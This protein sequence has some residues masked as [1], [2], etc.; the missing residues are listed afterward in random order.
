VL[1][2]VAGLAAFALAA[3]VCSAARTH[4]PGLLLGVLL[5]GAVVVVAHHGGILYGLPVG[6][7]SVLAFDWYF[8]PPLRALDQGTVFVLGL[9]LLTAVAV[10]VLASRTSR[11]AAAAE[12]AR[13]RLADEQ[14]ALRRV[15]TLIARQAPPDEVFANVSEEVRL[16][17]GVDITSMVRF[18][19]DGTATLIGVSWPPD[20]TGAER[21]RVMPIG[22][23]L[24]MEGDN[25]P[26]LVHRTGGPVRLD[27]YTKVSGPT[28]AY[29][30]SIGIGS[31]VGTPIVVNGRLWGAMVASSRRHAPLPAA[32]ES[33][34]AEFTELVA[35]AIANVEARSDLA[36]SG[37]R[38]TA[39]ADDERRRVVRDLHDGAQQRLVHTVITL[40][41]A[42]RALDQDA[43]RA[44]ALVAEALQHAEAAIA[45]LRELAHGL[46]PSALTSGGLRAGVDALA[47][48]MPM[49]VEIGVSVRRLPPAIEATAYF[50]VAEALTNVAKHAHAHRAEVTAGVQDGTLLIRVRDDGVGGAHPEGSGLRG[51]RDRVSVF[52]GSL[53]VEMAPDGGTLVTAAIPV[54]DVS[55]VS[56]NDKM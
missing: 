39:A 10:G 49:P 32:T 17:L 3:L 34:I 38:I 24:P 23:R 6:V 48:R 13:G 25:A 40:K 2:L 21:H 53:Q 50:V 1:A 29:G 27:D 36:A 15:A 18:E 31:A 46:L 14:A 20:V 26:S 42:Q 51:L 19:T 30:R 37:A 4:V 7:V 54:G 47:S 45:E 5:L 33:R 43:N 12:E 52:D 44:P 28:G 8:L 11:L 9:F 35:T 41:L 16:L 22:T 56:P 55:S